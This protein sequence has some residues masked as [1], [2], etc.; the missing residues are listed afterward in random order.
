MCT[1]YVELTFTTFYFYFTTF[2]EQA[3]LLVITFV[4][5]LFFHFSDFLLCLFGEIIQNLI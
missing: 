1:S 4:L 5:S 2:Q 3:L